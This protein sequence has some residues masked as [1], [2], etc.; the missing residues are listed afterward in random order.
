MRVVYVCL[1]FG[2]ISPL[3]ADFAAVCMHVYMMLCGVLV[4][5]VCS[6]IVS[7]CLVCAAVALAWWLTSLGLSHTNVSLFY[8]VRRETLHQY[9][10]QKPG[11]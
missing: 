7:R 8:L 3:C 2:G 4:A 1:C 11:S 5:D 6:A 10:G 9:T